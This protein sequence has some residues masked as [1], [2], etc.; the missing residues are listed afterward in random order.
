MGRDAGHIALAA[1][2]AGGADVILIPEIPYDIQNVAN[3][4][5]SIREKG[6]NFALVVVSEAVRTQEGSKLMN[7]FY[8]GQKRLGGIGHVIGSQIADL[9][10]A[11]TRVTVLGARPAR[12]PAEPRRTGLLAAAFGVHARS[13]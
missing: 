6:R 10:Q 8:G 12:R 7:E 13:S 1:G 2:I 4:I 11:E 3:H 5:K 9:C